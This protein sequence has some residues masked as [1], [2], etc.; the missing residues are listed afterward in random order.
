MLV[1]AVAILLAGC[2]IPHS[3]DRP[4]R[5]EPVETYVAVFERYNEARRSL[6]IAELESAFRIYIDDSSS[7]NRR[8]LDRAYRALDVSRILDFRREATNASLYECLEHVE[9]GAYAKGT[10]KSWAM[11]QFTP[12]SICRGEDAQWARLNYRGTSED[13]ITANGAVEFVKE[14]GAWK[15]S[16]EAF[17]EPEDSERNELFQAACE[18]ASARDAQLSR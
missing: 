10:M 3:D 7:E 1:P 16:I 14:A 17:G 6:P 13:G 11:A 8:R 9:C 15:I 5:T 18:D 2:A 12:I 4:L